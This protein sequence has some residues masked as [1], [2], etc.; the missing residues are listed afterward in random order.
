MPGLH[1]S[2]LAG[3]TIVW[4]HSDQAQSVHSSA[5]SCTQLHNLSGTRV[6]HYPTSNFTEEETG[7]KKWNVIVMVTN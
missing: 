7:T 1:I 5:P 4:G 2:T 3:S 6:E